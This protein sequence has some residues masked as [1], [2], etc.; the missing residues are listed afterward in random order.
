MFSTNFHKT[1]VGNLIILQEKEKCR[2]CSILDTLQGVTTKLL[3]LR[4]K[5]KPIFHPWPRGCEEGSG[6][7]IDQKQ[8]GPT[9]QNS[10]KTDEHCSMAMPE[11]RVFR[12][13]KK[14]FPFNMKQDLALTSCFI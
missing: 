1:V 10:G 2:P 5:M 9:C 4:H 12:C 11:H 13:Y 8:P 7:L 14:V 3:E 6:P